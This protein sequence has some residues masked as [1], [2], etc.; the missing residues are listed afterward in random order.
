MFTPKRTSR[1]SLFLPLAI[2]VAFVLTVCSAL[3][4]REANTISADNLDLENRRM[5][6]F[7]TL[8]KQD[9]GRAITDLRLLASDD[10]LQ[11]Y[12]AAGQPADL[13]RA[14]HRALFFSE[15]NPDY[16]KI[17][18]IDEQGHEVFRL[19]RGGVIV[20]QDQLQNKMDRPFFQK[21]KLLN[22]GQ[23]FVSTV[24]LNVENDA[25]ERPLKPTVRVAIPLFDP[26]GKR[27]GIYVINFLVANSF[28]RLRQLRFPQRFRLL[29][30][31]GYWLAGPKPEQ[32]WGFELPERAD[33]TM[34]KTDPD[35]WAKILRQPIGQEPYRGGYFTWYRA[36]P[37]D[38][39]P[40]KPV[41]LVAED[42]FL[43]FGSQI[44]AA[45]WNAS[46]VQLRQTFTV[47][48]ALLLILAIIITWIYQARRQVKLERDR[49]F[50]LTRDMLCVA[51]FDGYFKR[52]NPAWERA[53]GYSPEEMTMKPFLEF[54]H[55][56]DR[57]KTVAETANLASGGE[58]ISFE[59]R[60]RCKDG[61]YR[62]LL[63]SARPLEEEQLIYGSARD[64]TDRKQI[65]EK[66]RQ[67]EERL[68]LMVESVK[69][70]AILMLDTS[71]RVVSWNAG[72]GRIQGYS[73]EEIIGQHFSC[74]YP[75][76]LRREKLPDLALI[77][78]ANKGRA[79]DEGWRVRK[80]GS[81]FWAN[82]IINAV[83]NSQGD[84]L[85]FVKVTRDVSERRKAQEALRISEE[86]SRS[87]IEGAHDGFISID[88]GGRIIDWN[89]QAESI[90]GWKR[91][92]AMGRLLHELI[93]PE[94]YREAHL[95]G[96]AHLK[97]TGEGPVLNQTIELS[98]LRRGS[99]EFPLELVIWPLRWENETTFHAFVRD[100]TSRKEAA[101]SIEKLNEEL[102]Q[103]ADLLEVANQELESFSY[104]VSHDLRAPLRHIHGFVELLQKSPGVEQDASAQRY[105]GV[106]ARAAKGMGTL[107]DDLLALSRTGRAEMHP[108]KIQMR[109]MVDQVVRDLQMDC[110]GRKITWD[111]KTLS[112][113]MG[114]SGL[115]RLVW[116][117]L[118]GNAI[119]YTR[120]RE[121]AKIEIG[122]LT[123]ADNPSDG[124]EIVYYVRDNGVG[125]DMLYSTKLF[126]VFQRLHRPEEFEGTGI[127]LANVQRIVHRHGGRVWAEA[128]VDQGATF[129]FS[130]PATATAPAD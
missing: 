41:T 117:N 25:I 107:I 102:K 51:G 50:D 2:A 103:R 27:R 36:V 96:L 86:R 79:E 129:Y 42:D 38:F 55:P 54:V 39:Y 52:V 63:W 81:K 18:Y 9:I 91:T 57:A 40:D 23:I 75:E 45:E 56:E 70:Y 68:R 5:D 122:E 7:A 44:T 72:A 64:L 123:G 28:D 97:A 30:S 89:R 93:I 31:H 115:L 106:I 53:L 120:P 118:I 37:R 130:L 128:K 16:D 14:V 126:G 66:L 95:R 49:F 87:I 125:F 77:E 76:E 83:R 114:D 112:P 110:A 24:D 69:D 119:K 85:G 94:R 19:N 10:A 98:G 21:A 90:F 35:L 121:E 59:N 17:R 12:L 22:P 15:D 84:L 26:S 58:V 73:A 116:T 32:E 100:I 99:E 88:I 124:R 108:A 92:E 80:D 61:S 29:N 62:W 3:Y 113:V 48:G 105:M 8:Y 1:S 111:I 33:S 11:N 104:S 34:A 6:R 60:Y 13:D 71:G 65:E 43:V 4:L 46:F 20:P 82:V 47:V 74:F 127:G 109:D 101:R 78:A 67:S